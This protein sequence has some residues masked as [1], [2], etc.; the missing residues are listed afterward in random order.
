MC[1][2]CLQKWQRHPAPMCRAKSPCWN[3][4]VAPGATNLSH[5]M[6]WSIHAYSTYDLTTGST[7]GKT[8][9]WRKCCHLITGRLT[10]PPQ[11][12]IRHLVCMHRAMDTFAADGTL[13]CGG[14]LLIRWSIGTSN[15]SQSCIHVTCLIGLM[16]LILKD[17]QIWFTSAR[18]ASMAQQSDMCAGVN[19]AA[20]RFSVC[21][22]WPSKACY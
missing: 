6:S 8:V 9:S 22:V 20:A 7:I 16:C 19:D 1:A 4:T 3:M 2:R 13:A 14:R 17:V 18:L 10:L 15:M 11:S 5:G 12:H 21:W